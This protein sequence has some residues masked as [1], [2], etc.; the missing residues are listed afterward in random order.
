VIAASDPNLVPP[1]LAEEPERAFSVVVVS[2]GWPEDLERL[3][4][5]L[6]RDCAATDH[7]LVVV[8]NHAPALAATADRLAAEGAPVRGVHF[9]QHVGFSAAANA[10]VGQSLGSTVVLAL[11]SVEATGDFLTPLAEALA[12]PAVGLAGPWGLTTT[13]LRTFEE[14]TEGPVQAMQAYCM[15]FRRS[16][17]VTVGLFDTGFKFY[18]NADIDWSLRWLDNGFTIRALDLPL[19]RHAHREWEDLDEAQREKKSRDNFARLLRH[20]HDRS[21]LVR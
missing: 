19:R 11:T 21:D 2:A 6:D 13:D 12:D 8:A 15:A 18:R 20:W 16:D 3:A 1:R 9:M 5:S 4:A 7:E 14:A 10:G 17:A